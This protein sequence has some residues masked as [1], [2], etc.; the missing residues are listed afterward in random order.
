LV[1]SARNP[2]EIG[3]LP[4]I[5]FTRQ[6]TFKSAKFC[7]SGG[8][9][10]HLATLGRIAAFRVEG[11]KGK[12]REGQLWLSLVHTTGKEWGQGAGG[13][14]AAGFQPGLTQRGRGKA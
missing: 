11:V 14:Q 8:E 10:R 13:M 1:K 5:F 9:N 12:S 7:K 3:S 4:E 2:P 6:T